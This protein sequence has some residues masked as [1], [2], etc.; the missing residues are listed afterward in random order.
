[1][2]LPF[3]E[4]LHRFFPYSQVDIIAKE[5]IQAL[6]AYHPAIARIH[7]FHKSR[8]KGLFGGFSYGRT[9]QAQHCYDVF[10]TLAPSFSSAFI[11]FGVGCRYRIGYRHEARSIL[12]THS[13]AP[14]ADLLR[15]QLYYDLLVHFCRV[16]Q[17]DLRWSDKDIPKELPAFSEYRCSALR[18]PFSEEEKQSRFLTKHP[19][20]EYILFNVNSEAQSRRLP[21]EKWIELGKR[22]LDNPRQ[23]RCVVFSGSPVERLRVKAI[24]DAISR[25]EGILDYSGKT[26]LREL[27]L[28]LRDVD[29]V[30]SNDSGPMH[31]ANAVGTPLLTW[32]GAADP[33]ST[34]PFNSEKTLVLNRLLDCSPCVKNVCRFPTVRCLEQISVDEIYDSALSL[35]RISPNKSRTTA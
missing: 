31:L 25:P 7:L 23:K 17:A 11:G 2:S 6:Y 4:A 18:L 3:F 20:T 29:L 13:I 28:L 1:M 32:L 22:F 24:T 27:A 19:D 16:V 12:L 15:A 8:L 5:S 35:L 34:S 30:L 21:A 26:T 9:L 33:A 10:F 14:R